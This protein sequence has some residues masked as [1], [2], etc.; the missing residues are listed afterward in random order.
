M[1]IE[2]ERK[3]LVDLEKWNALEK[4]APVYYRQGYMAKEPEKTVRIRVAG[5][6][7]FITIKGKSTGATRLEYEYEIP[8]QDANEL[9][10]TFCQG[11]ITKKRYH[12]YYAGKLWEVDEFLDNNAG[13]YIAEIELTNEDEAFDLPVWAGKEVTGDKR[14]YNSNLSVHPY[15]ILSHQKEVEEGETDQGT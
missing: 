11:I 5:E 4:P 10:I 15:S 7:G 1:G 3:Y 9:L 8:L 6:K 13:L 12:V 14:Y 2:I